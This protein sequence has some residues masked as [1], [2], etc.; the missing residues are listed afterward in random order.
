MQGGV[1]ALDG[2]R[3]IVSKVKVNFEV[4]DDLEEKDEG[5]SPGKRRKCPTS[6]VNFASVFADLL[7]HSELAA[8][9]RCGV[10]LAQVNLDINRSN[11]HQLIEI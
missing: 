2:K 10:Q 7:P 3:K 4:E 1:W 11:S 9:E 5:P 6:A 8:A